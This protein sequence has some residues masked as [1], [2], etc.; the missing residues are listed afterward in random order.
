MRPFSFF[1]RAKSTA[2]AAR[3]PQVGALWPYSGSYAEIADEGTQRPPPSI[4]SPTLVWHLGIWPKAKIVEL[5]PKMYD[6]SVSLRDRIANYEKH[7]KQFFEDLGTMLEGLQAKGR[8]AGYT[9]R[10]L[11]LSKR[12][13][14][15]EHLG[16]PDYH[17]FEVCQPQSVTFTLWWQDDAGGTKLN[18]GQARPSVGDLRVRVQAQTH[19]DHATISFF[20]DV[21]KPWNAE[22]MFAGDGVS[23]ARRKRIFDYM[24]QIKA[25][26]AGQISQGIIDRDRLPERA[27]SA[28]DAATL[29]DAADYCYR[30]VWAEFASAFGLGSVVASGGVTTFEVGEVFADLR[31]VVLAVDGLATGAEKSRVAK[32]AAMRTELGISSEHAQRVGAD[33]TVGVGQFP[34]FDHAAGEPNTV[35]KAFWP[36]MRRMTPR[37]DDREFVAC[38]IFDWRALYIAPLGLHTSNLD[39]NANAGV[40]ERDEGDAL[41]AIVPGDALPTDDQGIVPMRQLLLTKSE[42]H[43]QQLGRIVERVNSI[44]TMRL[45][46]LR[47]WGT[48][49]NASIYVRL[50]GEQLDGVLA[51][52]NARRNLIDDILPARTRSK[53]LYPDVTDARPTKQ[54]IESVK[55]QLR[56]DT[57]VDAL[58]DLINYAERRLGDISAALDRNIG[59]GGSGRL[60]YVINRSAFYVHEFRRLLET[61]KVDN[62]DTWVTYTQFIERGVAPIFDQIERTGGRLVSLRSRLQSVTD[63]VQTGALIVQTEATQYNTKTLRRLAS[64]ASVTRMGA[65]GVT[66]GLA[67]QILD[68]DILLRVTS[69]TPTERDIAFVLMMVF[70]IWQ[71]VLGAIEASKQIEKS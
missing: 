70:A 10:R 52:W 14:A 62:I 4:G 68:R 47:N 41:E 59:Q 65:A 17:S 37:A 20:I 66:A 39:E 49:Q 9:P 48:I 27:V 30:G 43:R 22:R 8:I 11:N 33:A 16:D 46:A 15:A 5:D 44:G 71:F 19:L 54:P 23:G 2:A 40:F 57:R 38:G 67:L 58:T 56:K 32:A 21:A 18:T 50:I 26:G 63:M 12:T 3:A 64:N 60:L 25:I 55:D 61:L 36:F 31:T 1:T 53:E 7:N 13:L 69:M 35:L 51:F 42:P 45:F 24:A 34:R 6:I 28:A 29:G